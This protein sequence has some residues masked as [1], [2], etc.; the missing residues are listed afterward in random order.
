MN[1]ASTDYAIALDTIQRLKARLARYENPWTV[2]VRRTDLFWQEMCHDAPL[3]LA[4]AEARVQEHQKDSP[5]AT[6]RVAPWFNAVQRQY[7]EQQLERA[8]LEHGAIY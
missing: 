4:D 7:I 5:E 6:F 1:K 2:E 8:L 3:T